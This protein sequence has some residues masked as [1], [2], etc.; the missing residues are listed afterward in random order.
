VSVTLDRKKQVISA[1]N[2]WER[3]E[4]TYGDA[5]CCQFVAHVI[6]HLSGKDYSEAFAYNS[7]TE[8]EKLIVRFGSLKALITEILGNPSDKLLDGDPVISVFPII[9]ETMGVKLG[10]KVVCL[11]QKGLVRMPDKYQESGWSICHRL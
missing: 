7:K 4:F 1:L 2:A 3:R 5:D 6:K 10:N 9:G 8:A 11:T